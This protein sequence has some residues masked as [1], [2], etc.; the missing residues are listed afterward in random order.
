MIP[1]AQVSRRKF[2][3]TSTQTA[4][5]LI[6]GFCLP[7]RGQVQKPVPD[8]PLAVFKP[9]AW[10]RIA[11]DN[12]ITVLVEKPELGQ[13]SRTYTPMMI[14]EELEVDWSAIHVEQAPTIPSI[15]QNLRTGGS[16][17]VASTFTPM[18]P[19][20]A[21]AREMLITAAAQQ[22]KAKKRDCRAEKGT[23]VH[24]PTNRRLSYGEL[25]ET[26]SYSR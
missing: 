7:A 2:L 26:A 5:A 13:G 17:G 8:G 23:V 15:Y 14:A 21:Q 4:G 18:R 1:L 11:A 10:L 22:W 25:A 12:Q 16:G 19:V 9:N 3:K 24:G 20:G 6:L